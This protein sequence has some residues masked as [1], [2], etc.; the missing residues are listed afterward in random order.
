MSVFASDPLALVQTFYNRSCTL[1]LMRNLTYFNK[2]A[3]DVIKTVFCPK[4]LMESFSPY[5]MLGDSEPASKIHQMNSVSYP[6]GL[7]RRFKKC[8]R[9]ISDI[10]G[11]VF[12]QPFVASPDELSS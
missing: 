3:C 4:L 9:A 12:M 10:V 2:C 11:V 6:K 8:G 7:F 1:T 5:L